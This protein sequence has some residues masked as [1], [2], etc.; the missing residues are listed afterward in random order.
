MPG[1]PGVSREGLHYVLEFPQTHVH[2]LMM[3]SNP[4]ILCHPLLLLPSIFPSIRVFPSELAL[5]TRWPKY[6]SFSFSPFHEY[7]G[8]ITEHIIII[9]NKE[10]CA[11]PRMAPSP[12]CLIKLFLSPHLEEQGLPR[13]CLLQLGGLISSTESFVIVAEQGWKQE[14]MKYCFVRLSNFSKLCPPTDRQDLLLRFSATLLAPSRAHGWE[15]KE[16]DAIALVPSSQ[17]AKVKVLLYR[18]LNTC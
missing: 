7:S 10:M 4:L 2:E 16:A 3:P 6:W 9:M 1:F 8:L 14:V 11:D 17:S 5:L 15:L 12:T 18:Y 13:S